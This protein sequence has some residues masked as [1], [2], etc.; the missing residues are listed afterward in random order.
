MELGI[1]GLY[2]PSPEKTFA[3]PPDS[4][5][6][7][8]QC[9]PTWTP[10]S[11][12]FGRFSVQTSLAQS[13]IFLNRVQNHLS[14]ESAIRA[15]NDCWELTSLSIDFLGSC[16]GTVNKTSK[17]LPVSDAHDLLTSLSAVLTNLHTCLEGL[18]LTPSAETVKNDVSQMINDHF[19]LHSVSLALFTQGWVPKDM[20][21]VPFFPW[22]RHAEFRSGRLPTKI[23][24][25]RK[26]T[27]VETALKLLLLL[28][29]AGREGVTV[30]DFVVVSK[31]GNWDFTTINDAIAVAPSNT[32]STQGYF[33]IYVMAGV[34]EENVSIDKN[35][36]Y[37]Y[38]LGDGI[39]QTIITGNRSVGDN[40]TT[41]NS[42]TLAVTGQGFLGVDLTVQNTAGPSKG[43]AVALRNGADKSTFYRCSFEAYQDTLYAHSQ[44][45][46]YRECD[47]YGTVDF[48]FG[49]AAVV[50]QNCNIK[51]RLPLPGQFNAITAQGRTDPNQNT[52]TSIHNCNIVPSPDL[53]AANA[54]A[55]AGNGTFAR[56]YLGRPWKEYSRT[57]YMQS[58]MDGFIDPAG[59]HEWV[60]NDT[61]YYAEFDNRG[62]GSDTSRRVNWTGYHIIDAR[63]AINFTVSRF[64]LGDNWLPKTAISRDNICKLTRFPSYC[65]TI[66]LPN[67]DANIRHFGQYS[68]RTSLAQSHKFLNMVHSHL[69]VDSDNLLEPAAVRALEDCHELA[70]LSVDLLESCIGTVNGT[71]QALPVSQANDVHTW[72]SGVVTNLQTCLEGLESAPSAENVKNDMSQTINDDT[73]LHSVSLALF[74][75][76]WV[77]NETVT[78]PLVSVL[79]VPV[80]PRV[81]DEII[82]VSDFVVV[83]KDGSWDFTTINDAVAAVPDSAG[84]CDGYFL[85]YVTA[86]VYEEYVSIAS[87]KRHVFLL[88]D[89][90]NRT[91][92]T[93]NRSFVD[94]WTTFHSATLGNIYCYLVMIS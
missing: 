61:I 89:G 77:S 66:L 75:R 60:A 3:S 20:G 70:S 57:V 22:M 19:K 48:I 93:G 52:G 17:T 6:T 23:V 5:L 64:L 18:E 69:Q 86:G 10:T 42:A 7:A 15:L 82:K 29:G 71:T 53:A 39:N 45:Q 54:N 36:K 34:Y 40:S 25:D 88:G 27:I 73:K 8:P 1:D 9:S 55:T 37:L 84:A 92:I 91:I 12:D 62:P 31:D 49:N 47:I 68:I 90:I 51:P 79:K 38:L 81:G 13:Q 16:T 21:K 4:L 50:F 41:F 43:Q 24:S 2:H 59:W 85:I 74:T 14:R 87:S 32:N 35:K 72:L 33:L 46:F 28:V 11:H 76:G 78:V 56:T 63:D 83:S 65:N 58:Y 67:E 44:T 94:G 30:R 80:L 26:R